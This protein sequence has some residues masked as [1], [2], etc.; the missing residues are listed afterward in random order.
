MFQ[1]LPL[2]LHSGLIDGARRAKRLIFFAIWLYF[3]TW[4]NYDEILI[5]EKV[6]FKEPL[7]FY[8]TLMIDLPKIFSAE[9]S[10]N[11]NA[12]RWREDYANKKQH[13]KTQTFTL[14][15]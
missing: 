10:S 6:I 3:G 14:V 4:E 2:T 5:W 12:A 9:E 15:T 8:S 1:S 11:S 13:S 7:C